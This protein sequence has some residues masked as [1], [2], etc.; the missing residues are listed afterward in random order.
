MKQVKKSV[1]VFLV[2]MMIAPTVSMAQVVE[3]DQD[4]V[5]Q[6]IESLMVFM[7]IKQQVS[8]PLVIAP[9]APQVTAI[10]SPVVVPNYEPRR[11]TRNLGDNASGNKKEVVRRERSVW[12]LGATQ[13]QSAWSLLQEKA[14][15][16]CVP[17]PTWPN[18]LDVPK[19]EGS[20]DMAV[21]C[22]KYS[23][24]NYIE[25]ING[26]QAGDGKGW[27]LYLNREKVNVGISDMGLENGDVLEFRYEST[28][29]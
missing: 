15:I 11:G 8:A 18:Q 1:A 24:G 9:S 21:F 19:I 22:Y 10:A 16:D 27:I 14:D 20:K 4:H 6:L 12:V 7:G 2:G 26:V 28:G 3:H 23:F 29:Y 25:A 17:P 13:D 5:N